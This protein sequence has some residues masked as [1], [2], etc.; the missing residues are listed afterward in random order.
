MTK[1]NSTADKSVELDVKTE[2]E[3]LIPIR[4]QDQR[5]HLHN[6]T[7][8]ND[9]YGNRPITETLNEEEANNQI[10]L[11]NDSNL[12]TNLLTNNLA[13]SLNTN[14]NN[15]NNVSRINEVPRLSLDSSANYKLQHQL[16]QHHLQQLK[17]N[18]ALKKHAKIIGESSVIIDESH[19][20][21][22]MDDQHLNKSHGNLTGELN[23]HEQ[24]KS[25]NSLHHNFNLPITTTPLGTKKQA[26]NCNLNTIV[27]YSTS[28]TSINYCCPITERDSKAIESLSNSKHNSISSQKLT[29]VLTTPLQLENVGIGPKHNRLIVKKHSR[30]GKPPTYF[31]MKRR[32]TLETLENVGKYLNVLLSWNLLRDRIFLWFALSNFLTSL[33]RSLYFIL[34]LF[35]LFFF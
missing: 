33:G 11:Q 30:A 15:L 24:Y 21:D 7:T 19:L 17:E 13:T 1:Q 2:Q 16:Q 32:M 3:M 18:Q 5:H 35:Y 20:H 29:N 8:Y 9:R 25:Y 22:D 27:L 23:V 31:Q 14:L 6:D 26:S 10:E 28:M 4:E 34:L 12:G